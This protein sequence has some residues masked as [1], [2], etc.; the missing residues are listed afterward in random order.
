MDGD[1]TE[2]SASYFYRLNW[3]TEKQIARGPIYSHLVY[4]IK[5]IAIERNLKNPLQLSGENAG[6]DAILIG[7]AVR[8]GHRHNGVDI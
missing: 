7:I 5:F 1:K 4:K 6:V 2:D 3:F 8:L